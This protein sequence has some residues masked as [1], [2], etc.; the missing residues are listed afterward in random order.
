MLDYEKNNL[1]SPISTIVWFDLKI[2][3][4]FDKEVIQRLFAKVPRM[5]GKNALLTRFEYQPFSGTTKVGIFHIVN[6]L[7][8]IR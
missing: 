2:N 4:E 5:L 7:V 8:L 1:T 6:I 3:F